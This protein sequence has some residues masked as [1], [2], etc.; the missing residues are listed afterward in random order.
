MR[1][2]MT[3]KERAIV[4]ERFR[5]RS[6]ARLALVALGCLLLTVTACAEAPLVPDCDKVGTWL[7]PAT[8]ETLAPDRLIGSLAE[9]SVVLLGEDHDDA[10]HHRWQLH[11]L[12][13]LH[14]HTPDVIV[15]FEMFPRRLQGALD[16]WVGGELSVGTFLEEAQW[17]DVWRVDPDLYLPLFHFARQNRIA[18]I[19]INV[20]RAF[21]ARVGREGWAAIPA[22]ERHGLSDPAPA[23]GGYL[24]YLA[25]VVVD[26][27]AHMK[28]K[29]DAGSESEERGLASEEERAAAMENEGFTR[30]VEAQL[31]WDRAMAEALAE[32]RQKH[33][34]SLVVGILGRGHIEHGY[35]VPHQL[36]DLGLPDVA[37][38]LPVDSEMACEPLPVD[39][40][41]AVFVVAP[42][43]GVEPAPPKPRLG[44]RIHGSDD[45]VRISEVF[46]GS[47]AEASA[48]APGDIV[49]FAAGVRIERVSDLLEIVERQ[50]PGT[51][52]PLTIRRD[53]EER[54]VLAK[55]PTEFETPE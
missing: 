26:K 30:F 6:L 20:E 51:W 1:A 53:G 45:G 46:E 40:A 24:D 52:L 2:V 9:R 35:G 11:T 5:F 21:V 38:L 7:D 39:L 17:N 36:A 49:V 34:G 10:E 13:A 18:M 32:A 3:S 43:G 27:E 29:E 37:V 23:S 44:V 25:Q 47:V 31:A 16:R 42:Q 15:G 55:F 22:E 50:A 19:G 41:D 14:G 48:L 8:G 12:A 54:E 33:P 4:R 28:A